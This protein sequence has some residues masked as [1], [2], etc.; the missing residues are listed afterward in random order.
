MAGVAD[1]VTVA[2]TMDLHNEFICAEYV[3]DGLSGSDPAW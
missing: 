1:N 2:D 3:D